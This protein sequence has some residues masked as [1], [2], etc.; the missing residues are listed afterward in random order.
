IRFFLKNL[1]PKTYHLKPIT[2]NLGYSGGNNIGIKDALEQGADYVFILNPDTIIE[3]NALTKLIETAESNPKIGIAGPVIDEN[4]KIIY[5]GKIKWLKPELIH[6]ETRNQ[7][8]ETNFYIPGA[9]MLIKRKV[10]EKIGL[11]DERYFLYF[12][13]ADYCERAKRAGYKLAIAPEALIHHKPSSSTSTLGAPLLLRYHYR[14]AHL[15][16][17]K[18][19]PFWVKIVLPFWSIFIIIKQLAKIFLGNNRE[20]SKAILAGVLDFYRNHF[21]KINAQNRY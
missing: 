20:I 5:G 21:G 19:G 12:E 13:D 17:W 6:L 3:K 10:I 16:N 14:N 8:L 9:A 15:F 11:L 18:N 7:K 4:G 2:S 1:S